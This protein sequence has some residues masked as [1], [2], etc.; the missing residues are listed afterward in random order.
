MIKQQLLKNFYYPLSIYNS[1]TSSKNNAITLINYHGIERKFK[2]NFKLQIE[3]LI[4]KYKII[5]PHQFQN[6]LSRKKEINK[7]SILLTFDDGFRSSYDVIQDILNPLGIKVFIFIPSIML[8]KLN[9]YKEIISKNMFSG[10]YNKNNFPNAFKPINTY[11]I[12]NLINQ[13]HVIGAH[14]HTHTDIS[15]LKNNYE[16][17]KEIIN[18]KSLFK[19]KFN[20]NINS[21]AFP[22]GGINNINYKLLKKISEHYDYCFSNIRGSNTHN[23]S[24]YGIKR[25]NV[26][27]DMPLNYFNFIIE[28]GL[29]LYWYF[30]SNKLKKLSKKINKY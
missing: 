30:H 6:Y 18:P 12:K 24:R 27:P 17:N 7:H 1:I 14:T 10:R 25:Q 22:Y 26:S 8:S 28:G 13:G 16:L 11:N 9:N 20:I 19:N 15:K 29:D 5:S 3:S 21:F 4:N 23:T 2:A